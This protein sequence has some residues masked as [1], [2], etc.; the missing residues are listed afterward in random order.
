MNIVPGAVTGLL[1]PV[2]ASSH[3][4][5]EEPPAPPPRPPQQQHNR[6]LSVDLH[7]KSNKRSCNYLSKFQQK[8]I[9]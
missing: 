6:S 3:E 4:G 2:Q 1:I 8:P 9:I 7:G 5:T